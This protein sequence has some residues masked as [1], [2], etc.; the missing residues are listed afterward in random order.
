MTRGDGRG[1]AVVCV[2]A[3]LAAACLGTAV[4]V[5][6]EEVAYASPDWPQLRGPN[7]D[8]V[9]REAGWQHDWPLSGPPKLWER[10]VGTGASSVVVQGDRLFAI[11]NAD[12]QDTIHCLDPGTG[13]V[14]WQKSYPCRLDPNMFEGGPRA[15]PMIHDGHVYTVS[16]LGRLQCRR[17]S[18]GELVWERQYQ[19]EFD[20]RRP[21]WGYAGSVVVVDGKLIAEPGGRRASTVALDPRTGATIWTAGNDE[22]GYSTPLLAQLN[23]QPTL[24]IFKAKALVALDPDTGRELWRFGWRTDWDVNASMPIVRDDTVFISTGY[25]SGCALLRV[26]PNGVEQVY[27]GDELSTQMNTAVYHDGYV[28]GV[29]GNAGNG[30]LVCL[31]YET[32][33]LMWTQRGYGT[34]SVTIADGRLIVMGERGQ[35]ATAPASPEGFKPTGR[36]QVMGGRSWVVPVLSGG[37][38]YCKNNDGL[39]VCL[40]VSGS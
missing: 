21:K 3:L 19:E 14:I 15:T 28:Y 26:T 2:A 17:V 4:P 27:R 7:Q 32:G 39:I 38:L 35:L 31:D 23:G 9:S 40:D 5:N 22:P 30:V 11:G 33:E 25:G 29:S 13:A 6:A 1:G 18:D 20:G 16:H 12:D 34:G 8:G 36:M 10:R 37:R 24:L